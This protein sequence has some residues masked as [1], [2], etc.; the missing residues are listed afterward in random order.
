MTSSIASRISAG[1]S[2]VALTL[3]LASPASAQLGAL[4]RG[5]STPPATSPAANPDSGDAD[6]NEG[7]IEDY[8][9]MRA[10]AEGLYHQLESNGDGQR[11]SDFK[12][13]VDRAFEASS[14]EDM[15]RAYQMNVSATS[16]VRYVIEDK[17]RVYSGLY[18]NPVVQSLANRVG[19]SV[20]SSK[21]SRLYTFKLV[22]DPV[23]WADSLSTGTVWVSTGM[24]ALMKTKAQLAYVLAHEAAHIY[25]DHHRQR[26]MLQFAQEE[27]NRELAEN[28]ENRRKRWTWV[29][30]AA[31]A[32][33]GAVIDALTGGNGARGAVLGGLA[34]MTVGALVAG[35]TNPST[36]GSIEWNRFEEDEADRLAFDWL[37]DAKLDVKQVPNVY[38]ALR[39]LGDRDARVRLGFLGRTDRV[40]ERLASIQS[41]L[42]V[43]QGQPGWADRRFEVTDP[44]FDLLL[45]EVQ[46]DNGVFAFHYDML[47]T[48]R[49]NLAG[50]V[51]VKKNDPTVLYFYARVLSQTARTDQERQEADRYFLEAAKNDF[52]S[53]NYGTYLHRAIAK[54]T[55]TQVT[56]ADRNAAVE[57]LKQYVIGYHLSASDEQKAK[58]FNLPPHLEMVYDYLARAGEVTWRFDE[59]T[60]KR[61]QDAMDRGVPLV[62]YNDPGK[63]R[64]RTAVQKV[65]QGKGAPPAG[66]TKPAAIIKQH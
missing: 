46:R 45:A 43:E 35:A 27:Y 12:R 7:T 9:E 55:D 58:S 48:A 34:G 40:R 4:T 26:L 20:V 25:L 41:R 30:G 22:A 49:E 28:G 19:Q 62:E 63:P 66:E 36:L 44:T 64:A 51:A 2:V 23:P 54:L 59:T 57:Y 17:F 38:L 50:A 39:D 15:Q 31:S 33:G 14:K 53:Q 47:E 18:D 29:T 24:V 5:R 3:G 42:Q 13:R 11:Y 65:Q 56:A 32:V 61:V 16:E 21:V 10:F 52:R 6:L 60:I 1:A 37:L 8:L